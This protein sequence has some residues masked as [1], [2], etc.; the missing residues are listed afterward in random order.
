MSGAQDAREEVRLLLDE[1]DPGAVLRR[2]R[3]DLDAF[4]TAELAGVFA[5]LAERSGFDD[6]A[7]SA[8]RVAADPADPQARYDFGYACVERGAAFAAVPVLRELREEAPGS[9]AVLR[10]L[11]S[12]LEDEERHD[13]AADALHRA[14]EDGEA[15]L[16]DWPD[17]YLLGYNALLAGRVDLAAEVAAALAPPPDDAW[18]PARERLAAMVRRALAVRENGGLGP[19][20][21]R[22]WHF[23]LTGGVLLERSPFGYDEGMNGRYAMA[24]DDHGA[25]ARAL[26]R[27]I[28]VLDATGRRPD[29][30]D[31][32]PDRSS[33]ALGLAAAGLLGVGAEPFAGA[34]PG[35]L[36]VAYDLNDVRPEVVEALRERAPGQVLF[37]RS[38]CWTGPPAVPADVTGWLAQAVRSPWAE[39]MRLRPEGGVEPVPADDRPAEALA[40]E[41]IAAAAAPAELEAGGE[42][43]GAPP[44]D[45]E[46]GLLAFATGAA[47]LWLTGSRPPMPSS[48]PVPSNRFA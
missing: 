24:G 17:R 26:H 10:E 45:P 32:L 25:C 28:R 47:G 11:V 20:D 23:A 30:V 7:E 43:D 13:E 19:R 16:E 22:G 29:G 4:G 44:F 38:T 42:Q 39:S 36:V 1:G 27:L 46:E 48:G 12:A 5:R 9:P 14:L 40:E 34:R 15:P 35:R 18:L 3:Q 21:L 33:R 31:L 41:I 6:L 37:E 2:L 8:G